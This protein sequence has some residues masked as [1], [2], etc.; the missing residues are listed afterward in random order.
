M[1]QPLYV[2]FKTNKPDSI[3]WDKWDDL[4]FKALKESLISLLV[5][6]RHLPS[7][8]SLWTAQ[9]TQHLLAHPLLL[10]TPYIILAY[11]PNPATPLP[12]PE[13]DTPHDCVTLI[14]HLLT[15]LPQPH[16]DL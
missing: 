16:D 11:N 4:D 13:D 8:L 12:S 1:A 3:I 10:T 9:H 2:L 7:V 14:G 6:E 15:S 5:L